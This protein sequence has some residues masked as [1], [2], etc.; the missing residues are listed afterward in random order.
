[1][2]CFYAAIE[3]RDKPSLR[4][5]PVAVGGKP[6]ARGVLCT[7]NYEA[8]KYGIHSAMPSSRAM[9]LCPHLIILPVNF[10][11]YR[12]AS[13]ALHA[14][15]QNY[16]DLVEPLSLDEAYLDVST[17]PLHSGSATLIAQEIRQKIIES[18]NI[19]ASAGIA[20]NKMLAKIA[21]DWNKPNGQYVI[22]PARV[23]SFIAELPIKKLYGVG[24]VTAEKLHAQNINTCADVQAYSLPELIALFGNWGEHLHKMAHGIDER[25]IITEWE[26]KSLS[27]E[28]TYPED[29][30]PDQVPQNILSDIFSELN[31]RLDKSDKS[32]SHIKNIVVKIK[33]SD[34]TSTTAQMPFKTFTPLAFIN[35]FYDRIRN[36]SRPIRLIG[37]GVYFKVIED[38]YATRQLELSF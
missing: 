3:V 23:A 4:G 37:F 22:T 30:L 1:M 26:R 14:I 8:R 35:L 15:F 18:Q 10:D 11:K 24:K 17:S 28:N 12:T 2:D 25:E 38:K 36:E 31:T 33:F 34:F 16:T 9:R 27:V 20:P 5:K 13:K 29:F 19:T 6:G 21:S 7:C 32:I